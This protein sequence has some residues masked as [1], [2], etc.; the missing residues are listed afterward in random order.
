MNRRLGPDERD[1]RM[2]PQQ[3]L[4]WL[5]RVGSWP[6][7][8]PE[9]QRRTREAERVLRPIQ[10]R[11]NRETTVERATVNQIRDALED[12]GYFQLVGREGDI[13]E[14]AKRGALLWTAKRLTTTDGSRIDAR[15]QVEE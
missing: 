13:R 15:P 12:G 2:T 3:A 11:F 8:D 6:S 4:A 10:D 7:D 1:D 9:V 14:A 5:E